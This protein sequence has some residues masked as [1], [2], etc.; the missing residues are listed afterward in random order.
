M[1]YLNNSLEG[2]AKKVISHLAITHGSYKDAVKLLKNRFDNKRKTTA[3]FIDAIMDIPQLQHRSAAALIGMHDVV[4][5]ALLNLQRLDYQV[6]TWEPMLVTILLKKLDFESF[7]IFEEGLESPKIMPTI[8]QLLDFLVRRHQMI[9]S[10]KGSKNKSTAPTNF[11]NKQ[12]YYSGTRQC[13]YC[14]KDHTIYD[15]E[16]FKKETLASRKN[17]IYQKKLCKKCFGHDYKKP[18]TS[19]YNCRICNRGARGIFHILFS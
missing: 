14:Q 12:S 4:L 11:K 5:E 19:K 3:A 10:L 18:C 8:Q 6:A 13:V 16:S 7:K 17:F 15:C 2:D 1:H 9:E